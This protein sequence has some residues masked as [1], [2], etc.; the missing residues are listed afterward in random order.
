MET[1]LIDKYE[2]ETR[3][4]QEAVNSSTYRLYIKKGIPSEKAIQMILDVENDYKENNWS[5]L[6]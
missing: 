1:N 4:Q 5:I 3:R 6:K 2:Y